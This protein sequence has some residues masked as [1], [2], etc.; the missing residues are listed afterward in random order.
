M[1]AIVRRVVS[2]R[3]LGGFGGRQGPRWAQLLGASGWGS[4]ASGPPPGRGNVLPKDQELWQTHVPLSH[5]WEFGQAT[6]DDEDWW[7][8][9]SLPWTCSVVGRCS[10]RSVALSLMHFNECICVQ[11]RSGRT[12][13]VTT[14][15]LSTWEMWVSGCAS[16]RTVDRVSSFLLLQNHQLSANSNPDVQP[17][18]SEF[19]VSERS[20]QTSPTVK[21]IQSEKVFT[22]PYSEL[23]GW[24]CVHLGGDPIH[25]SNQNSY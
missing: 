8:S 9:A 3:A 1:T 2:L 21:A 4:S 16:W 22:V 25:R 14:R 18:P 19:S 13:V 5:H 12:W 20:K 23:N 15:P 10:L 24:G 6:Q 17:V 11:L 7:V